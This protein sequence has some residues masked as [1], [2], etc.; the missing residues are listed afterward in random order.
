[1]NTATISEE[2]PVRQDDD[3]V[4]PLCDGQHGNNSFCQIME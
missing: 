1:M 4:C 3:F 2:R